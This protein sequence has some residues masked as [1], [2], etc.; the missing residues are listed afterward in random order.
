MIPAWEG[1]TKITSTETLNEIV[2]PVSRGV[3]TDN[4]LELVF[5]YPIES[6]S[7]V[8]SNL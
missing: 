4:F 1:F 3:K 6:T 2:L 7:F 5:D 8:R